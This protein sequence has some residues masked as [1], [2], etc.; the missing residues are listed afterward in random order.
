MARGLTNYG[1]KGFSLFLRK[2]FI[3]GAGLSDDA[4]ARPIIGI[5]NTGS[6]YNPCHGN[7]RN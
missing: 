6:S 3:K 7:A 2:A 1:D 5:V 4:L